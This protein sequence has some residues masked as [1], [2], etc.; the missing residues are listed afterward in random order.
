MFLVH[1][2]THHRTYCEHV[3]PRPALTLAMAAAGAVAGGVAA[4]GAAADT[5]AGAP[6]DGVCCC[7]TQAVAMA[8]SPS[9]A[10]IG[11]RIVVLIRKSVDKNNFEHRL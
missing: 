11:A 3:S 5:V 6:G 2:S 8:T 10:K 7:G 1:Q 4:F 9:H